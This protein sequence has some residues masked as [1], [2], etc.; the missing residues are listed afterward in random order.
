MAT[1]PGRAASPGGVWAGYRQVLKRR[2]FAFLW[3]GQT[4]S[5]S[6]QGTG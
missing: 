5:W 1:A 4:V 3:L 6:A 2:N